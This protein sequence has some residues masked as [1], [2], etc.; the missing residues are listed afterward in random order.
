VANLAEAG[1]IWRDLSPAQWVS[2]RPQSPELVIPITDG[3]ASRM[4][5]AI[6]SVRFI[7]F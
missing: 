6:R 4:E 5:T 1:V 3:F 7:E 2:T